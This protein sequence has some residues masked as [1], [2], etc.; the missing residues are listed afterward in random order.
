MKE[1]IN[2]SKAKAL[3]EKALNQNDT[4]LPA[5]YLLAQVYEEVFLWNFFSAIL[6]FYTCIIHFKEE[7]TMFNLSEYLYILWYI[8]SSFL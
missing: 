7:I 3:L 6:M 5:V 1:P 4:Y 8:S 2:N